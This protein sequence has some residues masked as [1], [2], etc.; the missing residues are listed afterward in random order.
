M[1]NIKVVTIQQN[2]KSDNIWKINNSLLLNR[3]FCTPVKTLH[4]SVLTLEMSDLNKWE[5][6]KFKLKK[7]AIETGKELSQK[8][9]M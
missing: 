4:Q 3:G 2:R 1:I 5:W 6:L 7:I 9:K 8:K